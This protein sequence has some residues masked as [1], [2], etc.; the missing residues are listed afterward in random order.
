MQPTKTVIT[1]NFTAFSEQ[2]QSFF[3]VPRSNRIFGDVHLPAQ[4]EKFIHKPPK[5]RSTTPPSFPVSLPDITTKNIRS[6]SKTAL[7]QRSASPKKTTSNQ[8]LDSFKNL[9][10]HPS[11]TFAKEMVKTKPTKTIALS[12]AQQNS[13]AVQPSIAIATEQPRQMSQSVGQKKRKLGSKTKPVDPKP[14]TSTTVKAKT[15][16]LPSGH[17]NRLE[18]ISAQSSTLTRS[19]PETMRENSSNSV[20]EEE[21]AETL[22]RTKPSS[23]STSRQKTKKEAKS[24]V[25][26]VKKQELNCEK[27][28]FVKIL[29]V[30]DRCTSMVNLTRARSASEQLDWRDANRSSV[31]SET[32]QV[33]SNVDEEKEPN[34]SSD[35]VQLDTKTLTEA[36]QTGNSSY[37]G[38]ETELSSKQKTQRC[39][40]DCLAFQDGCCETCGR[41]MQ[42]SGDEL[43]YSNEE[44]LDAQ[45]NEQNA[46][47]AQRKLSQRTEPEVQK[48]AQEEQ[49]F[50]QYNYQDVKPKP[51][52]YENA[53]SA[54]A[55]QRSPDFLEKCPKSQ[56][57]G[58]CGRF[59]DEK[60]NFDCTARRSS[61]KQCGSCG[62]LND[63]QM[64]APLVSFRSSRLFDSAALPYQRAA[65]SLDIENFERPQ[66]D[67]NRWGP[68]SY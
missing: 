2:N 25:D 57:C 47:V 60:C 17:E 67:R 45:M 54:P 36:T 66:A 58:P 52:Y 42:T 24:S 30:V 43:R 22:P 26:V 53:S 13:T 11:V 9:S 62:R 29:Y 16:E 51:R 63:R 39:P 65:K 27:C 46:Y 31:L 64:S 14:V 15:L 6:E 34:I 18:T 5:T 40:S 12:Q 19:A 68:R 7:R 50:K 61:D 1:T 8:S 4:R 21:H 48:Y 49:M 28:G 38:I 23:K 37:S 32:I 59:N 10:D 20:Q 44:Y 56:Q 3:P 55:M 33:K 35:T 41:P